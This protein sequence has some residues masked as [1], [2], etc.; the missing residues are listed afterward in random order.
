[1][2]VFG[3]LVATMVLLTLCMYLLM[4]G[5][6]QFVAQVA[7]LLSNAVNDSAKAVGSAMMDARYG[8]TEPIEQTGDTE[9]SDLTRPPWEAWGDFDPERDGG[10]HTDALVPDE[11]AEDNATRVASVPAGYSFRPPPDLAGES[12]EP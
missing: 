9:A 7:G 1:M 3:V 11:A 2:E 10:D 5:L 12:F 4:R 6:T 8:S